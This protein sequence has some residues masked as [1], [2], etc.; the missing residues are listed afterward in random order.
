MVEIVEIGNTVV[1]CYNYDGKGHLANA[2]PKPRVRGSEFHKQAL[3]LALK[4]EDGRT[5]T[6]KEN[7]F[8]ANAYF[9]DEMEDLE[10]NTTVMLMANI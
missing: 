4:D 5:L 1:R 9:D 8:M 6:D 10:A 3:L 2:C 7:S